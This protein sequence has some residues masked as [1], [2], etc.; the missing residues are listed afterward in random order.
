MS[1]QGIPTIG[2]T[3]KVNDVEM[4]YVTNIGAMGG[5]PNMLDATCMKDKVKKNV[6]G[7][8]DAGNFEVTY[9]FDNSAADSDFR[10][11]KALEAAGNAVPIEIGLPDGTAGAVGTKLAATAYVHTHIEAAGVDALWTAKATFALQSDWTV[12]NPTGN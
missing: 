4:N 6:P 8:Q 11:L 5:D 12:T 2:S 9:L 10:K 1:K 3:V 7:V